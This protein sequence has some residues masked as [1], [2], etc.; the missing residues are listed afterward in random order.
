MKNKLALTLTALLLAPL[1]ALHAAEERSSQSYEQLV[2]ERLREGIDSIARSPSDLPSGL[3][4]PRK[5]PVSKR[6]S[7]PESTKLNG[8]AAGGA[9]AGSP[10][11]AGIMRSK[12]AVN[13]QHEFLIAGLLNKMA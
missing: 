4:V 12:P 2:Q 6:Y 9:G 1:A 8:F 5:T 11:N 7:W 10:A 13:W 3:S